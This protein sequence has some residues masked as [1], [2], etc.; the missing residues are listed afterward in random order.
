MT[1]SRD[2]L[3]RTAE[4]SADYLES[5]DERPVLPAVDVDALRATL[6][7][8]LQDEPIDAREVL[9]QLV[10]RAAVTETASV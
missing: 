10:A 2:L 7:R 8:P 9:E 6:T 3:A 4:L 5:L 1:E